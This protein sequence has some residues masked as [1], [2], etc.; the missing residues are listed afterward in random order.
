[1]PNISTIK[2]PDNQS[3]DLKDARVSL[4]SSTK[5]TNDSETITNQS[6][7]QY[8]V[9]PDKT[10]YLSVNVPWVSGG[11][12]TTYTITQDTSDGHTFTLA[13]TDGYSQ[14]ITIPDNNTT[15][16]DA[17]TSASGLMSSTDKTALNNV[18][19]F[20]ALSSLSGNEY[21]VFVDGSTTKKVALSTL[22][23]YVMT[24]AANRFVEIYHPTT[25]SED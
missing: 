17:T 2:L 22:I 18:T 12:N 14:S 15:Y 13:G 19:S 3:Y 9:V 21:V 4:K 11:T 23:E 16:S 1:M 25:S 5:A 6:G 24:Q 8:A 10:G 20:G 7:R